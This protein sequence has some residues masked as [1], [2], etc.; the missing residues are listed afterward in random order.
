MDNQT[1]Q[2]MNKLTQQLQ[3]LDESRADVCAQIHTVH[4]QILT[5]L[6]SFADSNE[7]NLTPQMR[8]KVNTHVE[9]SRRQLINLHEGLETIYEM[10]NVIVEQIQAISFAHTDLRFS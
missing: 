10:M 2:R 1:E 4:A 5:K 8:N 6:K 9:T 3:E 7:T